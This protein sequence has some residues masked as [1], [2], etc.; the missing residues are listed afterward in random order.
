M[1]NVRPPHIILSSATLLRGML[2]LNW[3]LSHPETLWLVDRTKPWR[4]RN[5]KNFV[6]ELGMAN[7]DSGAFNLKIGRN[8]NCMT[9][10]W[11]REW[12]NDHAF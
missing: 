11:A 12:A 6:H 7:D 2:D 10:I 9:S 8:G 1:T 4:S 3:W 5:R